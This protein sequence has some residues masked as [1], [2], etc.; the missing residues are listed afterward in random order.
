MANDW[1]T[2]LVVIVLVFLVVSGVQ[3]FL[4]V[5]RGKE[6]T[7]KTPF[8]E[9]KF[10][11][12]PDV[13]SPKSKFIPTIIN[14]SVTLIL[15]VIIL[16]SINSF[17]PRSAS[18][19]LTSTTLQPSTTNILITTPI[20]GIGSTQISKE[21]G[22]VQMYVPTGTF[23]MGSEK[24]PDEQ[25]IHAV[26]LD[27]FWI[28]KFEVT[29]AMYALCVKVGKC[30]LPQSPKSSTRTAYFSNPQYD[31]H[32]VIYVTWENAN[33]YCS[34]TGRR[35]PSEAEWE[36]AARGTDGRIYPWGNQFDGAKVN[37]YDSNPRVGDTTEAGKYS[38]GA[39]PYSA[40]DMAG[41]IWEWV[42]DWY[43][44]NYYRNSPAQNPTGPISG[45]YRVLRGGAWSSNDYN[46]R[47]SI[48]SGFDPSN[49]FDY[50]GFR[51]ASSP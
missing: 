12:N 2:Y 5:F 10:E 34:W 33:T 3:L 43:D 39:S 48:R 15:S 38:S 7:F 16:A 36:K 32:P 37:S 31:N 22:M 13:S 40:L 17:S 19:T 28:D 14:L 23:T 9:A 21:D 47:A 29:N 30:P 24:Y 46:I 50:I 6:V 26:M 44:G 41:N 35:L 11:R 45:T 4:K 20:L 49:A 1:L 18:V 8:V 42:K 27:A 51:C 25:P